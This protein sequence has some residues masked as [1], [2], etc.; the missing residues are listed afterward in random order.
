MVGGLEPSQIAA[1]CGAA[2]AARAASWS[3]VMVLSGWVTTT[4]T[5]ASM[6][7]AARWTAASCSKTVVTMTAAGSPASSN[8][9]A[10][11]VQHD[12]QEPQSP[13]PISATS[14]SAAIR[15]ISSGS[16]LTEKLS[17]L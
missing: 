14:F 7:S 8:R 5:S 11:Y 6:P 9:T 2:S 15:A 4:G 3:A 16:A 17:F 13:M 10:S 12:V 1:A